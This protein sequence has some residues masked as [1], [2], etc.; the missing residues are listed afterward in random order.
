[1]S[2]TLLDHVTPFEAIAYTS[3]E[4]T[5]RDSPLLVHVALAGLSLGCLGCAGA[6]SDPETA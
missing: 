5:W 3:P 4:R 6:L 1:M 2:L